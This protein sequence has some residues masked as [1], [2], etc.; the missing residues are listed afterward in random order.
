MI[1]AV[2]RARRSLAL[3][4]ALALAACALTRPGDG[5]GAVPET[6]AG[7]APDAAPVDLLAVAPGRL[8]VLVFTSH[9]C[10]IANSYAPTLRA[11]AARFAAAPVEWYLVHVDP[12]LTAA[13]AAAH[14]RDFELPGTIVCEPNQQTA[15]RLGIRRTPEAAVLAGGALAYCGRIDDQWA[16][17]GVRRAHAE[18]NDLGDAIAALLAGQTPPVARTT[19]VGCLLPEAA[20]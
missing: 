17:L 15:R 2:G 11:L 18:H 4:Q 16:A 6:G 5:S 13:G 9:E 7:A 3:L 12:D 19:A 1:P 14:A 10:P 8:R 20:R